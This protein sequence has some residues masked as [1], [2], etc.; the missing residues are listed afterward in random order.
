MGDV[1]Y[2]A[3]YCSILVLAPSLTKVTAVAGLWGW[4]AVSLAV[5]ALIMLVRCSR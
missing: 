4:T 3:N 5:A 1:D 2:L